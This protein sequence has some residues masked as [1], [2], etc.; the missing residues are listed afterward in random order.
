M[1]ALKV[2]LLTREFPPEVYGGAG[3]HVEY[4][5]AELAGMVD[6]DVHAFGAARPSASV[7]ATYTPWD[8]LRSDRPHAAAL[9][10]ISVDLAM[11]LGVEGADVVHTHT[12]YANLAGHLASLL[13]DVPHVMTSHSLEP[14]RPWKAEQLGGGYAVS[15]WAE[16][17]SIEAADAVV[18][19]S[20]PMRDDILRWYPNVDPARVAVIHN[21]IDTGTYQ[22]TD[23]TGAIER[24]GVDPTVPYAF[25]VGRMTRQKGITYLLDAARHLPPDAPLVVLASSPD[26]AE[27]GAELRAKAAAVKAAG[28]PLVFVEDTPPRETVVQLLSHATV[29]VCPSIYEPFGLVNAEAMACETAVVASAVGGITEVV[30]DGETGVLV[31]LEAAD[32][33]GTPADPDAYAAALGAAI[34]ELLADPARADAYGRAGRARVLERFTWPAIA[35]RTVELYRAVAAARR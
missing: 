1:A 21:G 25:F 14:L 16:R 31:P 30:V 26:T 28:A 10:T 22:R 17:A 9:G 33:T 32:A 7:A 5:A 4:L 18:A 13:Y 3:V 34:A 23:A 15:S 2:A 29:F 6:L 12:W 20:G 11:A 27:I 24:M 8:A 35:A 19:V